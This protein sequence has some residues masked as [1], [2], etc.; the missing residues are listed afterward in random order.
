MRI[1]TVARRVSRN[2][3]RGCVAQQRSKWLCMLAFGAFIGVAPSAIAQVTGPMP[4]PDLTQPQPAPEKASVSER[5]QLGLE[6]QGIRL[7]DFFL[8]PALTLDEQANNNIY[9]AS[10]NP[11]SDFITVIRPSASITSDWGKHALALLAEGDIAKYLQHSDEDVDNIIL[12][13]NGRLDVYHGQY[14]TAGVGW[15]SLH[16]PQSAPDLL[17]LEGIAGARAVHPPQYSV[18]SGQLG[19]VYSPRRLGLSLDFDYSGFR[20]A[21]ETATNGAVIFNSDRNYDEITLTPRASYELVPGYQAYV[22]GAMNW[23][24]YQQSVDFQDD[25]LRKSSRGVGIAVGAQF[26]IARSLT[27]DASFGY[28]SQHYDDPRLTPVKGIGGSGSILWNPGQLTSFRLN[29]SR[30]IEE[31][32]AIGSSGVWDTSATLT[33][34]R[35]IQRD[36][37]LTGSV[38]FEI[39]S[40]NGIGRSDTS[41]NESIGLKWEFAR[42][43]AMNFSVSRLQRASPE[44]IANF[45]QR[46]VTFT[47]SASY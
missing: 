42:T 2:D 22:Q 43:L 3:G 40:Y 33:V 9:G 26:E 16:E 23:R 41:N 25:D 13:G 5:S 47:L 34:E 36:L 27:G 28:T 35:E 30:T 11:V 37:L 20:F 29:F 46:L 24:H 15:Q 8:L 7:G 44:T 18:T 21:D 45:Y 31:T 19:Y 17:T 4:V 39:D 32:V 10:T 38:G 1:G 14:L 6:P 12:Q